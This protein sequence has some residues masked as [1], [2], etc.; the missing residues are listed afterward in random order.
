MLS[1]LLTTAFKSFLEL[2]SF[3]AITEYLFFSETFGSFLAETNWSLKHFGHLSHSCSKTHHNSVHW[4]L[5]SDILTEMTN[6][7]R[8]FQKHLLFFVHFKNKLAEL[9]IK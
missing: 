8:S 9:S 5:F 6:F 2:C 4:P 1:Q 7:F 3:L